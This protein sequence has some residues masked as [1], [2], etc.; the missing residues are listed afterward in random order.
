M[1]DAELLDL[2]RADLAEA[3][4]QDPY[5][6]ELY[7]KQGIEQLG[8]FLAACLPAPTPEVLHTE[9]LFEVKIA[10]DE[11]RRA[12]RPHRPAPPTAV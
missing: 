9:E 4:I 5:Q 2:F 3:G 6:H 12:H 7:E 1:T 11:S 8:N 10:G